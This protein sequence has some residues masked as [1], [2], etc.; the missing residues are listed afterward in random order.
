MFLA[1][2]GVPTNVPT[3]VPTNSTKHAKKGNHYENSIDMNISIKKVM[4]L[5][6]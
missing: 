2:W 1:S 4:V 3:R 5:P 6:E